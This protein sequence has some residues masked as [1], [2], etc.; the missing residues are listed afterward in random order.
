MSEE[1]LDKLPGVEE[2]LKSLEFI[3]TASQKYHSEKST[4]SDMQI[5][6][7]EP[8][9][10]SVSEIDGE[11]KKVFLS[12]KEVSQEGLSFDLNPLI[13]YRLNSAIKDYAKLPK[14]ELSTFFSRSEDSRQIKFIVK[15][16]SLDTDEKL[17]EKIKD[18]TIIKSFNQ[19]SEFSQE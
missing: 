15:K 14:I 7:N 13:Y 5:P 2:L 9:Y 18:E 19:L 17:I 1:V 8:L 12:E 4:L 10:C 3:D 16:L 6:S 11:L